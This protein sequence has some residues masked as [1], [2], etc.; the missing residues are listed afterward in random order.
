MKFRV[1]SQNNV[2]SPDP[3]RSGQIDTMLV[4]TTDTGTVDCV[5]LPGTA[6]SDDAVTTAVK[7]NEQKKGALVG[8][9][10]EV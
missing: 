2:P 4:Y 9:Q 8:R 7:A 6:P 1:T 3:M 10:F 5:I